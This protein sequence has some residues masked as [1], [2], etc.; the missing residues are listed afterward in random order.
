MWLRGRRR[1]QLTMGNSHLAI[2]N[3]WE[4]QDS[5]PSDRIS[6]QRYNLRFPSGKAVAKRLKGRISLKE[7]FPVLKPQDQRVSLLEITPSAGAVSHSHAQA[8][9]PFLPHWRTQIV[10]SNLDH[11]DAFFHLSMIVRTKIGRR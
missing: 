6:G 11:G 3:R 7:R 1:I 10:P 8:T 4:D 5:E 2:I 9:A